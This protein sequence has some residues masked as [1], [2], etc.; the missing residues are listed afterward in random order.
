MGTK[1]KLEFDLSR[2]KDFR[3][4]FPDCQTQGNHWS[5]LVVFALPVLCF[6][7]CC[8]CVVVVFIAPPA[9]KQSLKLIYKCHNKVGLVV[10]W[11][12]SHG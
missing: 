11:S 7:C 8:Y 2:Y 10:G 3:L 5:L 4:N 9:V 12:V 6:H 1:A